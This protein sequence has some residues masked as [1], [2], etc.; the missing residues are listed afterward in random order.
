MAHCR[1][2]QL[3]GRSGRQPSGPGVPNSIAHTTRA[4]AKGMLMACPADHLR[5]GA[6]A[7]LPRAEQ[8]IHV[9]NHGSHLDWVLIRAT[10]EGRIKRPRF[11]P[12]TH[13]P[14]HWADLKQPL[15]SGGADLDLSHLE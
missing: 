7:G 10:E 8:P 12:K 11:R 6:L 1:I 15:E 4:D 14:G 2:R 3:H 13:Q 5:A 9:A